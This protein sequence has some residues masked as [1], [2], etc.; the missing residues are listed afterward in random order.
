MAH[1][2]PPHQDLHCLQILLFASLVLKEL[3][4]ILFIENTYMYVQYIMIQ[5]LTVS[6]MLIYKYGTPEGTFLFQY[7]PEKKSKQKEL[8]RTISR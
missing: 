2:E 3:N 4:N 6:K 7:L 8:E 1:Y 5:D